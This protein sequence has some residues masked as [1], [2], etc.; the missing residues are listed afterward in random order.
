M[1]VLKCRRADASR[2]SRNHQKTLNKIDAKCVSFVECFVVGAASVR[3]AYVNLQNTLVC[4]QK[5]VL[6]YKNKK[7][8]LAFWL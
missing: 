6:I 1:D 7:V 3:Y 5:D 8:L 4:V 2:P